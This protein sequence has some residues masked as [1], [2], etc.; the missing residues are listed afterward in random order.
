MAEPLECKKGESQ[1]K[2]R[3]LVIPELSLAPFLQVNSLE[4]RDNRQ[5][6]K[7]FEIP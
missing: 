2:T 6:G 7:G 5:S 3:T 4:T 1:P